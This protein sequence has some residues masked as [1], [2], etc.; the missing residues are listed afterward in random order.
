MAKNL[1]LLKDHYGPSVQVSGGSCEIMK[2]AIALLWA[3][4]EGKD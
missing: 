1:C 3:K 4:D 2:A